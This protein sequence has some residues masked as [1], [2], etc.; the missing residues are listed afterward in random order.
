MLVV[1]GLSHRTAPV[2][3]RERLAVSADQM[4]AVLGAFAGQPSVGE[5]MCVSTCNRVEVVAAPPP[6][7]QVDLERVAEE[8]MAALEGFAT[9]GPGAALR[10]HL[11]R[12]VGKDAVQHLFRV[13][14]SLDSIVVGEPQI[15]GQVKQA[16][17]AAQAAG[18]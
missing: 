7:A 11:Y 17:E 13:A 12:K 16:F 1:V 5:V 18:T 2:E 10:P 14:S 4:A 9:P 15:L 6:G 3:V 8:V